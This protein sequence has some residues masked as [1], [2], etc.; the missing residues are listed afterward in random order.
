MKILISNTILYCKRWSETVEFYKTVLHLNQITTKEWFSEFRLTDTSRL[1]IA[2]ANRTSI[3]A[4][5][6]NGITLSLSVENIESVH[7]HLTDAGANPTAIKTLWGSSV[8]YINDPEGNRI[9][10]WSDGFI[11]RNNSQI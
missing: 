4:I 11:Q 3:E 2:N 5:N 8:F 1:S 6:G 7:A 10:F 9:E